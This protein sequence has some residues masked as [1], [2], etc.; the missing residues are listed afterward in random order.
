[1]GECAECRKGPGKPAGTTRAREEVV[2]VLPASFSMWGAVGASR[3]ER[4]SSREANR[5]SARA[6]SSTWVS[7]QALRAR[8]T[9]ANS[10]LE[11]EPWLDLHV[12]T[13]RYAREHVSIAWGDQT[14]VLIAASAVLGIAVLSSAACSIRL[15]ATCLGVVCG[16]GLVGAL[17]THVCGGKLLSACLRDICV[18]RRGRLVALEWSPDSSGREGL[19]GPSARW[20][21]S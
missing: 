21:T 1:M 12:R 16:H 19:D 18:G 2:S 11:E 13:S 9:S 4:G 7:A 17:A 5:F 6:N 3:S 10:D 14:A 20:E 15:W 8:Q